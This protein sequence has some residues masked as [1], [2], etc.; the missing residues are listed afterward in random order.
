MYLK[1]GVLVSFGSINDIMNRYEADLADLDLSRS[2]NNNNFRTLHDKGAGFRIEK[3]LFQDQNQTEIKFPQTGQAADLVL[4]LNADKEFD[5]LNIQIAVSDSALY[6]ERT[7]FLNNAIDEVKIA[8]TK[9][10]N[11]IKVH[12]P[13]LGLNPGMYSLKVSVYQDKLELLDTVEAFN[14]VVQSKFPTQHTLF[15]QPRKW[16][17]N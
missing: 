8:V 3:I 13:Y 10:I 7:F 9:G 5:N 16:I 2:D 6:G 15:Y 11:R 4:E 12:F 14:F 1:K 17:S